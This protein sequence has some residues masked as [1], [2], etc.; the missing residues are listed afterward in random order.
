[1]GMKKRLINQQRIEKNQSNLNRYY[2]IGFDSRGSE[3]V[4]TTGTLGVGILCAQTLV[5]DTFRVILKCL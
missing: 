1:M 2:N 4:H 3:Y 5:R